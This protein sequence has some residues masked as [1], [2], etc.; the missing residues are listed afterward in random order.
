MADVARSAQ[1]ALS[2]VSR[3]LGGKPGVS[4]EQRARILAVARELDYAV[5][6]AASGLASGR[7]GAV[8]VLVPHID[9][10]FHSTV[11]AG[12]EDGLRETGMDLLLYRAESAGERSA[13]FSALPF[14]RRVDALAVVAISLSE[15]ETA[16]LA[17]HGIPVIGISCRLPGQRFV[18]IDDAAGAAAAVRHLT[19]L[20]HRRIA[21]IRTTT[22]TGSYGAASAERYR[23]YRQAMAERGLEVPDAYVASA[24]WG[25]EGGAEAMAQLLASSRPPTAVFCESDEVAIGALR[26]LRRSNLVPGR[27]LSVMGFDDHLMADLLDLSTVAQPV[28]DQ[29]RIG[30]DLL[31]AALG[32]GE[33]DRPEVVLPTR[34]VV[35]GTT[36]SPQ[37][38]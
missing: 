12:L 4:E 10:W 5:S 8:G 2:T 7:T 25:V 27:D 38:R 6:P 24:P 34:L 36:A 9:R 3:A 20:G 14:R 21:V 30:A 33:A 19:N 15:A 22:V 35:R 29:G 32:R 18:G 1:V 37:G 31:L 11:L 23:G 16:A 13:F 26:T 28:Q 17:G